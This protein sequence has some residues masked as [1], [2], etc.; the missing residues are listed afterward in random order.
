MMGYASLGQTDTGLHMRLVALNHL[1]SMEDSYLKCF[2][3]GNELVRILLLK[4]PI[5]P[6]GSS[7]S[8]LVSG[9][10]N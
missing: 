4:L 7:S 10:R 6:T 3:S 8:T 5:P 2:L 9:S 1:F